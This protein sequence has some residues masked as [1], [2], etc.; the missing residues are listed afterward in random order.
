MLDFILGKLN[1]LIMVTAIFAIVAY[2]SFFVDQSVVDRKASQILSRFAEDTRTTV[3]AQ[4]LCNKS[5]LTVP[6]YL[7]SQGCGSSGNRTYFKV[8]I[9][10]ISGSGTEPN[11]LVYS[12]LETKAGVSEGRI[13]SSEPYQ[14]KADIRL[15]DFDVDIGLFREAT[16]N[17]IVLNPQSAPS[18]T[19]SILL[20]KETF[21]G[22]ETLFVVPCSS[23]IGALTDYCS[24]NFDELVHI[25]SAERGAGGVFNCV[26]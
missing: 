14:M 16:G 7:C 1:L 11:T 12:L 6:P 15:F 26:P 13:L 24:D 9:S 4:N 19:D 25:V 3:N 18:P 17:S 2:F 21:E 22:R 10:R 20:V 5:T 23:D 8:R